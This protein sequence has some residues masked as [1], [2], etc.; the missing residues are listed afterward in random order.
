MEGIDVNIA[1]V[2]GASLLARHLADGTLSRVVALRALLAVEFIRLL[3]DVEEFIGFAQLALVRA[4]QAVAQ[5]ARVALGQ[6][7]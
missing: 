1:L 7:I 3:I 2:T 6:P 4:R 5:V